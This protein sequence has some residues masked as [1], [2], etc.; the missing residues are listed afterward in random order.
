M[1]VG[2]RTWTVLPH[3]PIEALTPDLWRVEGRLN[4]QNRRVMTLA[5][6]ADG[7]VIVHN[8]VA[9]DEPS[10]ARIDAW[11]EVAAILVP[12]G[13]HRQDA[14][15]FH[16]RYPTAK[17]YA[18]T[19]ALA[20]AAKATAVAGPWSEA[21]QDAR[22]T[23]R[24]LDGIGQREGVMLV[25]G[26]GGTS[27][28][29]CD[30][31]LNLPPMGGLFGFLLHPTG[32]LSVPRPTAWWFAKDRPALAADLRRIAEEDGLAR[33]IPGHGAVVGADAAARL[34]DAADRL[35]PT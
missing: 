34:R 31:L 26:E 13:F 27:A 24:E 19:G 28:V 4:A 6:L 22:V 3:D 20:A 16:Q 15:I 14:Y 25:R 8:A 10:M 30:T 17:V 2:F 12:N 11:G 23:L 5:R 33:V 21:P 9:L 35:A 7:R 29:F 1:A 32:V 18:P